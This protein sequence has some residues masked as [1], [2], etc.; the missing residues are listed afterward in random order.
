MRTIIG[1]DPGS[2]K[3]GFGII[4]YQGDKLTY[5]TSGVIRVEDLET[6]GERLQ[7][8]FRGIKQMAGQYSP[9]EMAIEEIFMGKNAAS[10][11]KLGQ[12]RGV[13]MLAGVE[14]GMPV[15]EYAAR[16]VKQAL[17]GSGGAS[18]EQVQHMVKVLLG[19]PSVPQEDAADALAV[20]ICHINSSRNL[21]K[22][23]GAKHRRGRVV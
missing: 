20:A 14:L 1:I 15:H 22:M 3:T 7:Q 2:R 16:K 21:I 17:V 23:S 4:Q 19:L 18:K 8:I 9:D 11:L 10:A 13:A 6:M 12:A 5:L